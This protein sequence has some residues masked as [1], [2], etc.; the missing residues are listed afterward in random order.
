MNI[1]TIIG[2]RF[3][4][5]KQNW[6]KLFC[7]YVFLIKN[8]ISLFWL[9]FQDAE[10]AEICISGKIPALDAAKE[11]AEVID[12]VKPYAKCCKQQTWQCG[13]QNGW[14]MKYPIFTNWCDFTYD[15]LCPEKG[16]ICCASKC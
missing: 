3:A 6:Q 5:T 1:P 14:C 2:S 4:E 13:R 15:N 7:F 9:N 12:I 8:H 16:C 11:E 10:D